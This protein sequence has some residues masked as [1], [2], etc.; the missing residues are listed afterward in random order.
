MAPHDIK[1]FVVVESDKTVPWVQEGIYI[2]LP[3]LE[4]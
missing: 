1:Q 4:S 3:G 2:H